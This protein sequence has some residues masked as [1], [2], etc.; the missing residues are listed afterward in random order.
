MRA[1][2][3]SIFLI[4]R[5]A[6][7]LY[8]RRV[9]LVAAALAAVYP[10]FVVAD[11]SLMTESLYLVMVMVLLNLLAGAPRLSTAERWASVR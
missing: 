3:A 4:G 11:G 9:G 8:G 10:V 1:G 5:F 6:T 7:V 2:A